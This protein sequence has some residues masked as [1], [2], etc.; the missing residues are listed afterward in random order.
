L[1]IQFFVSKLCKNI[2]IWIF[3]WIKIIF[4]CSHGGLSTFGDCFNFFYLIKKLL[5]FWPCVNECIVT[6]TVK[7][8]KAKL[9]PKNI[10]VP[11]G[12]LSS[13]LTVFGLHTTTKRP[14]SKRWRYTQDCSS[15]NPRLSVAQPGCSHT[16]LI[17]KLPYMYVHIH[18]IIHAF[19]I[20]PGSARRAGTEPDLKRSFPRP[21]MIIE[22]W[23]SNRV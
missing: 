18:K 15:S 23:I 17:Q 19:A 10:K 12:S 4:L 16:S 9:F 22:A 8:C 11:C 21:K 13:N 7:Q 14:H 6:N 20:H 1:T 3:Y 2:F 5:I